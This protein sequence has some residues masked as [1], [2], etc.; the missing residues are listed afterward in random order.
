[1]VGR[2]SSA[3]AISFVSSGVAPRKAASPDLIFG[4]RSGGHYHRNDQ[5]CGVATGDENRPYGQPPTER[6]SHSGR[7]THNRSLNLAG[8]ILF[9]CA[10]RG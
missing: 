1:M 6:V 4:L 8:L 3:I 5:P 7:P 10:E 9:T 2:P